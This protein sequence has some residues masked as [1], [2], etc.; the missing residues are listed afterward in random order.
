M[1]YLRDSLVGSILYVRL[2]LLV[3]V[4]VIWFQHEPISKVFMI[5]LGFQFVSQ[6]VVLAKNI[7]GVRSEIDARVRDRYGDTREATYLLNLLVL[8]LFA[9]GCFFLGLFMVLEA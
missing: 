6:S 9:A 2:T 3:S 5:V 8:G 4:F 7:L 1:N